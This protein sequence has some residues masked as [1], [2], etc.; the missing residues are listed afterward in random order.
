MS[1]KAAGKWSPQSHITRADV[2]FTDEAMRLVIAQLKS[3]HSMGSKSCPV[4][5]G[6]AEPGS[7]ASDTRVEGG[8]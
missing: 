4:V 5:I 7:A 6:R 2:T 8:C 3:E 1:D